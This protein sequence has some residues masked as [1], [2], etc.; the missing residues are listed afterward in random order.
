M[1]KK[2]KR[3]VRKKRSKSKEGKRKEGNNEPEVRNE[4]TNKT[5]SS[6]ISLSAVFP[7]PRQNTMTIMA[8][9]MAATRQAQLWSLQ[10]Q[11]QG[12][13]R[14]TINDVSFMTHLPQQGHVSSSLDTCTN[15][16]PGTV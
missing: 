7:L 12:R 10:T 3:K 11:A 14:D 16:G 15:C 8:G 2:I 5:L 6:L 9:S 13:E 4:I 1:C